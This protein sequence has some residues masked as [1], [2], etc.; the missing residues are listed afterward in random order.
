MNS[1]VISSVSK[2][3][4]M[5]NP[6]LQAVLI[7]ILVVLFGWFVVLPKNKQ[8]SEK[9]TQLDAMQTQV[10]NL[11]ADLETVNRLVADLQT[12]ED[13]IKLVDEALPLS[14]RPTK[15]A[16][17]LEEYARSSGMQ[18][19]QINVGNEDMVTVAGD[20]AVLE[21]PYDASRAL[22]TTNVTVTVGGSIEQFKNFLTLL[23]TSGRIIDVESF[24]V[25]SS[26]GSIRY[27]LKLLT[28]AYEAK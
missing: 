19:A 25:S 18:V 2:S 4:Q 6:V 15:I 28:Y 3:S 14:N 27:N 8:V 9:S 5:R 12:S 22:T 13:N 21:K 17:L 20:K 23:E 7:V 24:S 11:E 26:E 16:L 1:P 10:K